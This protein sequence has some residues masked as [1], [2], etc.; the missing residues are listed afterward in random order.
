MLTESMGRRSRLMFV[1]SIDISLYV[2]NV[3][4]LWDF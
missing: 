2:G 4:G 3:F 1:R